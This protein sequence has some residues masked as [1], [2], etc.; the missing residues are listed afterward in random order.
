[1]PCRRLSIDADALRAM[2]VDERRPAARI[3]TEMGCT[4]TTIYRRLRQLGIPRRP[5]GPA[6]DP[7]LPAPDVASADVA[8]ALGLA[9][10]DGNLSGDGRHMSFVSKDRDLVETFVR[11]LTLA[12]PVRILRTRAG[13]VFYRVQW[14]DRR[15][16]RWLLA[17][18][19]MPAKSLRLGPLAIPDERFADFVRGCIDGDGS[20]LVYADRYHATKKATYV[21]E[22]LY[23]S[24]VSASLPFLEWIRTTVTRLAN[25]RGRLHER[26]LPGRRPTWTLRYAKA[27]SIEMIRWMYYTPH[28]PCLARKRVTAERVLTGLGSG[29]QGVGRPRAGWRYNVDASAGREG[30]GRGGVTAAA[31]DSKSSAREGV[32]VRFPPPVPPSLTTPLPRR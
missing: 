2:Y 24:L 4:A 30:S 3:A 27:E 13:G 16:Y 11:C 8:Y 15:V 20:I 25:L 22:R 21:Y 12:T 23:V 32:R 7:S 5:R 17:V 1:V 10:T 28:V 26:R 18:G 14:A 31:L 6:P 9:A 19:L 29:P